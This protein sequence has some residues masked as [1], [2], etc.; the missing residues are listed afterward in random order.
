V[1]VKECSVLLAGVRSKPGPT[2]PDLCPVLTWPIPR[3][4]HSCDLPCGC[5]G[6]FGIGHLEEHD[7]QPWWPLSSQR[8]QA[9]TPD[10]MDFY[11]GAGL[12]K[13]N[14]PDYCNTT[15]R[16]P[17]QPPVSAI[18][19]H[20]L[21]K[22]KEKAKSCTTRRSETALATWYLPA[23]R[24]PLQTRWLVFGELRRPQQN[25]TTPTVGELR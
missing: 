20:Q 16:K 8:R 6:T 4:G 24:G 25:R 14:P 21:V 11:P 2:A 17:Q 12:S 19:N 18:A 10:G 15:P 13:E 3:R 5:G 23:A 1:G 22:G 9:L 7:W